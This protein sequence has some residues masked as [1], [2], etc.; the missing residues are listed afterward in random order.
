MIW[1]R[2]RTI[3]LGDLA[4]RVVDEKTRNIHRFDGAWRALEWKLARLA[5]KMIKHTIVND[6]VYH[7]YRQP[8]NGLADTPNI[9][10]LFTMTEN[11][12]IVQCYARDLAQIVIFLLSQV[13]W[14]PNLGCGVSA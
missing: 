14:C 11:E 10:I 12:V 3:I 1:R 6:G 13:Y 7:L 8:G 4:R 5:H 2:Y 9:T